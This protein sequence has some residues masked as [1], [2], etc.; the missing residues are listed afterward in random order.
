MKNPVITVFLLFLSFCFCASAEKTHTEVD[1]LAIYHES[2]ALN[3]G[4]IQ[5]EMIYLHLDNTSYYRND[6][7][8]FACYVVTSGKLIPSNMSRTVYVELLNPSGKVIDHCIL[9]TINGR[10]HGSLAVKE[11]PFYSG[12]YEVR[13]YTR[14]MLSFGPEAVFSR[15]IPVFNIPK[16]EGNWAERDMLDYGAKKLEFQR[17][18]PQKIND[19]NVRFYPE[20][21]RLVNGLPATVAFEITDALRRPVK[22]EGKVIERTD[23]K[24]VA[25]L[26]TGHMGR[27]TFSFVP[28]QDKYRV[29]FTVDG[30]N[31]KYELPEVDNDGISLNVDNLRQPDSVIVTVARTPDCPVK[32]VG[33]TLTCRNEL[34]GRY[35]LDLTDTDLTYFNIPRRRLPTGIIQLTLFDTSGTPIADRLFFNDRN[36]FIRFA[37]EFNKPKYGPLEPVEMKIKMTEAGGD[38]PRY[39]PFSISVTDADNQVPYGS[40][41]MADI[42]LSSEVK[43][44]IHNPAW[45]FQDYSDK[46]RKR[47]LDCLLMI[48]GW[49][50][51]SWSRLAGM[52]VFSV[53]SIPEKGIEVHGQIL[54]RWRNKPVSGASVSAMITKQLTNDSTMNQ[55]TLF[56]DTYT[57]D[58]NGRF[59]FRSY[60]KG[61]HLLTLSTS[62]KGKIRPYRIILNKSKGPEVRAYDPAEMQ[63]PDAFVYDT[64]PAETVSPETEQTDTIIPIGKG[65]RLKEVQVT[66]KAAPWSTGQVMET[67]TVSYDIEDS[68][69]ALLDDGKRFIRNLRDLLP[70]IDPNFTYHSDFLYKG[71]WVMFALDYGMGNN[72]RALMYEDWGIDDLSLLPVETIKNVYVSTK[73]EV[74]YEQ[75]CKVY[76]GLP[77]DDKLR[78]RR[79]TGAVVFIELHPELRVKMRAGMR[80]TTLEGYSDNVVEFYSPDYSNADPFET[81]Y[82][83]TI[84]WNPEVK[85]D[86]D[87]TAR[88][89]FFNNSTASRFNVSTATVTA[90]GTLG[91]N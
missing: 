66:A 59:A 20:G 29:E 38:T 88:V 58:P 82:R 18:K 42:L 27:G 64:E 34:C 8:F 13:A 6:R 46:N 72:R 39:E 83:R 67:A 73:D 50:R 61:T 33:V 78:I 80:R 37:Y 76:G 11:T 35:T 70:Q 48:Q 65:R 91:G 5:Q 57:T 31:Y 2:T 16:E 75:I 1:T 26:K 40:N 53:D 84:Y 49:R 22:A 25:S 77:L 10:C 85:P 28:K 12:Y 15:V 71:R 60:V 7:I 3:S 47:A 63:I 32:A 24:E 45:Y 4:K 36:D 52:E 41:I 23:R 62:R 44:Y 30:K 55:K 9:K 19:I 69:D 74:I 56:L 54:Q 89:R 14:Y 43:G 21:G 81:D 79:Y 86:S 17:P 87:G 90:D 51:Y 68:R